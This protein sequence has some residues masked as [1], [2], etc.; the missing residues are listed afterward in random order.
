MKETVMKLME[1]ALVSALLT[2]PLLADD[3]ICQKPISQWNAK[4]ARKVLTD[5]A[6][7]KQMTLANIAQS[8]AMDENAGS[9]QSGMG[10]PRTA[11]DPPRGYGADKG[12]GMHGEKEIF[13]SY[14]VRLFSALPIRQAYVRLSQLDNRYD[15]MS[16]KAKQEFDARM[17]EALAPSAE[18]IVV[19][20]D[21]E[22]NDRKL[23]MEV[24]RQL[25]QATRDTL[26]Q[27]AYL[28]SDHLGRIYLKDYFPPSSDGTGAKLVFPRLVDGEP[29]VLAKDKLVKF[30]FLVPGTDHKVYIEWK[31]KDLVCEGRVVL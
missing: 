22:S 30:E 16:P 23:L 17:S 28:I 6:W 21:F 8:S 20:I 7:A 19:A 5:S 3:D 24:N 29:V 11:V 27:Q 14:T 12:S 9:G 1:I 31:V 18:D 15:R 13:Y 10:S 26:N 25:R 4:K 2:A